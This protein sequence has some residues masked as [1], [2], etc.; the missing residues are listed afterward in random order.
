ME[1]YGIL[2]IFNEEDDQEHHICLQC[3]TNFPFF[4]GI[5]SAYTRKLAENP[6]GV[7]CLVHMPLL[8]NPTIQWVQPKG[9]KSK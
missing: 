3:M 5:T 8:A 2:D 1:K 9:D 6:C 4:S 7:P